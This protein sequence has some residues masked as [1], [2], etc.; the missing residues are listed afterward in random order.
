MPC[1]RRVRA[2]R[3]KVDTRRNRVRAQHGPIE[4]FD[5]PAMTM[6]F[7]LADPAMIDQSPVGKTNTFTADRVEGRPAIVGIE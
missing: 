2:P 6:V 3:S 4:N 1:A 7:A 5:M